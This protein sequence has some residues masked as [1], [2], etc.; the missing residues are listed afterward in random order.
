MTGG[1]LGA[2]GGDLLLEED[3][4]ELENLFRA[5]GNFFLAGLASLLEDL[6]ELLEL[7]FLDLDLLEEEEEDDE[8]NLLLG[9]G[10]GDFDSTGFIGRFLILGMGAGGADE[11]S[12]SH[13]SI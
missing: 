8:E 2:G 4:E 1:L 9:A 12:S 10:V 11:Q 5:G 6:E 13:F 7:L 3:E